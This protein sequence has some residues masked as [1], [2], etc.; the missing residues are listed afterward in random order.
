MGLSVS[1]HS[2]TSISLSW[3]GSSTRDIVE[4]PDVTVVP[5]ATGSNM[6]LRASL[7]E[8]WPL[9]MGPSNSVSCPD[10]YAQITSE[11][12]CNNA[13]KYYT[14]P[15]AGSIASA[16]LPANCFMGPYPHVYLNTVAGT[17]SSLLENG[18]EP[19]FLYCRSERKTDIVLYR[20]EQI[21]P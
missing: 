1:S 21:S 2:E 5:N 12:E 15:F 16:D 17:G 18:W 9:K 10:G 3:A 13:A 20:T 6:S 14:W 4:S 7:M 8:S 19:V 11:D